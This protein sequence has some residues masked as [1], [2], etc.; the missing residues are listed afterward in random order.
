MNDSN[1][2]RNAITTIRKKFHF[3]HI[4]KE[5]CMVQHACMALMIFTCKRVTE[6]LLHSAKARNFFS[7]LL[8]NGN[9]L[10]GLTRKWRQHDVNWRHMTSTDV[11]PHKSPDELL[12]IC[13]A[14]L[15]LRACSLIRL[16]CLSPAAF[17]SH[18]FSFCESPLGGCLVGDDFLADPSTSE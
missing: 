6:C 3:F 13:R 14:F 12:F 7:S 9:F 8:W 11:T 10:D 15:T 2:W 1:D 17:E 18:W 5:P 4:F 16:A